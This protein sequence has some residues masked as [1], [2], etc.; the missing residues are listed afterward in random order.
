MKLFIIFL[1]LP[2]LSFGF[3]KD[4]VVNDERVPYEFK[5]MFETL[6]INAQDYSSQAHLVSTSLELNNQLNKLGKEHLYFLLKSEIYKHTLQYNFT[7]KRLFKLTSFSLDRLREKL[8]KNSSQYS[9]FSKWI[10]QS[11]IAD[12]KVYE[13]NGLVT[14]ANL[15]PQTLN[16]EKYIQ[17]QKLNRLLK[18]AG[19]WLEKIDT[20]SPNEFNSLSKEASLNVFEHL[21]IRG[22]LFKNL[23]Q[24]ALQADPID[25][26][27]VP[28]SV[29]SLISNDVPVT[30]A[31]NV[32][33]TAP[34][35]EEKSEKESLKAQD[36]VDKIDTPDMSKIS[37][38]INKELEKKVLEDIEPTSDNAGQ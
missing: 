33:P 24:N 31:K 32:S 22:K 15:N 30:Q 21:K 23:T 20:L 14:N 27:T 17:Y 13:D 11:L 2:T 35:L 3:N 29:K 36:Q 19:P 37:D 18:Y 7:T 26:I 9:G 10:F 5:L 12:C 34:T 16:A 4:F 1:F 6:K 28:D 38:D 8:N 25:L